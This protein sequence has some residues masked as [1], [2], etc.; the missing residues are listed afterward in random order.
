MKLK[1]SVLDTLKSMN[2]KELLDL[3]LEITDI[4]EDVIQY[5]NNKNTIA[6]IDPEEYISKIDK[7]F[8]DNRRTDLAID[9]YLNLR[10]IST[11]YNAIV[12]VGLYL[13]D[14]IL[15][16]ISTSKNKD[17][18]YSRIDKISK[19]LCFDISKVDGNEEFRK[20]YEI[21]MNTV[22]EHAYEYM[23]D[24]YYLYF[25]ERLITL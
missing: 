25:K 10:K 6:V 3:L 9:V 22:G 14:E 23:L 21:L 18:V 1:T 13:M 12:T 19:F 15:L 2:K 16:D 24:N 11:D 7:C 8:S 4:N 20:D 5:L 17:K